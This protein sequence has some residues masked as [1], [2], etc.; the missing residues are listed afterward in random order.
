MATKVTFTL[1]DE[2]VERLRQAAE[3][4]QKPKSQIV[5]EAIRDFADRLGNLSEQERVEMLKVFDRVV[6]AIPKRPLA[7][8]QSELKRIRESRR[9]GGRRAATKL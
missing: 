1:D 5:R 4:I 2:T 8:V 7:E 9:R 6:P 3:R